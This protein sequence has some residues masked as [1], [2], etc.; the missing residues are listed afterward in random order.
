MRA[1][2]QMVKRR[3]DGTGTIPN[4]AAADESQFAG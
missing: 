2:R 3:I 1:P 4:G